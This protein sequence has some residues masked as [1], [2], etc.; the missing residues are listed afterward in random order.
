M[1]P[2]FKKHFPVI[3]ENVDRIGYWASF[4]ALVWSVMSAITGSISSISQYGWGAVVLAGLGVACIFALVV[5]ACLVAWRYFRPLEK[6][7]TIP[8][9]PP[10]D[11]WAADRQAVLE[12]IHLEDFVVNL[13]VSQ[14]LEDMVQLGRDHG[15]QSPPGPL[16]LGGEFS[17]QQ[18][19]AVTFLEEVRRTLG[20]TARYDGIRFIMQNAES[21]AEQ[22][23]RQ[24]PL[25][26]RPA[27][28]DTLILENGLLSITKPG[29]F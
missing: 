1:R 25:N 2:W 29:A 8:T 24:V 4:I 18:R 3:D 12:L 27:E 7:A 10:Q 20:T 14:L 21:E 11:S 19:S 16:Q 9:A 23:I 22:A 15:I 5:S 28:I 26:Q 17:I 13:V 6:K